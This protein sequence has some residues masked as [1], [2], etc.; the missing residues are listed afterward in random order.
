M[1][2]FVRR[3]FLHQGSMDH[4]AFAKFYLN[5]PAAPKRNRPTHLGAN[6]LLVWDGK[7]LL[8][9]RRDCETWGL[10]GG[11][12][13][14]REDEAK[15]IAREVWEETGLRVP[16]A[17]FQR[18]RVYG[19]PGRIASYADGSVWQMVIILY[20]L[21]LGREPVLRRS[22]ESKE[23]RFFTKEELLDLDIICTHRDIVMDYLDRL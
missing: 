18:L 23:L 2:Q 7:L 4:M 10:I 11:G 5:D 19:V 20:R 21:D 3:V 6:V 17:R 16:P 14:G 12:I 15:A 22:A 9:R 13:K 1:L 8:E